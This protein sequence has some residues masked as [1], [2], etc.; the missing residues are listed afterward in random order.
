METQLQYETA[1]AHQV[2]QERSRLIENMGSVRIDRGDAMIDTKGI[3]QPFILKGYFG[4]WTHEVR[5]FML[6]RF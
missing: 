5:T 1:R 2:E 3:G 4:E 6:A